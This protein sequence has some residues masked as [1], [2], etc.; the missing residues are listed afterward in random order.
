MVARIG[1]WTM[2][3]LLIANVASAQVNNNGYQGGAQYPAGQAQTR[4]PQQQYAPQPGAPQAAAPQQAGPPGAAG[5]QI[6]APQAPQGAAQ[7]V[8]PKEMAPP[9]QLAPHELAQLNQVLKV[10]EASSAKINTFECKFTRWQFNGVFGKDA[11]KNAIIDEGELKYAAPD[12]G[13][14]KIEGQR[15]EQW[16]CDGKSVFEFNY[17]RKELIEHQ[18]PPE[19]QGKAIVNGPL[20]FMFG[21]QAE[22]LN[23]RYYLRIVEHNQQKQ[24]I[25][26]VAYPRFQQDAA[27]FQYIDLILRIKNNTE[28]QPYAVQIFEPNGQNWS[29]YEFHDPLVNFKDPLQFL[30]GNPFQASA[31]GDWQR[32]V[33]PPGGNPPVANQA[34]RP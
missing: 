7:P 31:P 8:Q 19:L 9:F 1:L 26:L 4:P 3:G 17:Q 20:P 34:R 30:K 15:P 5:S 27:N 24:E 14:Y 11:A 10:W 16:I 29:V 13:S 22:R 18:L 21:A 28:L 2:I 6:R 23:Q 32:I 12:K 33:N 25:R